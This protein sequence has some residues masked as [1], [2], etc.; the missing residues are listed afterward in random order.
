MQLKKEAQPLWTPAEVVRYR[1]QC[2]V[3]ISLAR[4][5]SRRLF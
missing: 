3:P 2:M 5:Y 4:D 1:M